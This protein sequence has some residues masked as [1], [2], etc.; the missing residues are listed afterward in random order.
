MID[1]GI[2]LI[3]G[4]AGF[5]P[6]TVTITSAHGKRRSAS[7]PGDQ[8]FKPLSFVY[9]VQCPVGSARRILCEPLQLP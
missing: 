6:S 5:T 3:M 8:P 1:Y 9:E 2:L 7:L 4:H